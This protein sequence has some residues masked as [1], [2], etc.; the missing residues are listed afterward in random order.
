[1]NKFYCPYLESDVILTDERYDHIKKH[2]PELLPACESALSETLLDP[3]CVRK[4]ARIPN[5]RMFTK[6]L[7]IFAAASIRL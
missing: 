7:T 6:F 4:S 5:A 1:M 3:D 2:H